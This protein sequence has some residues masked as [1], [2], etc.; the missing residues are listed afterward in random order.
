[1]SICKICKHELDS[2]EE[3]LYYDCGGDCLWCMAKAGDPECQARVAGFFV[4]DCINLMKL[5]CEEFRDDLK[6][7]DYDIDEFN[8]RVMEGFRPW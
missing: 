5:T 3:S 8:T 7:I 2:D 4:K 6:D 1:M